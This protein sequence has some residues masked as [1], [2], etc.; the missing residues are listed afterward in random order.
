M[1]T[2]VALLQRL[3]SIAPKCWPSSRRDPIGHL[4]RRPALSAYHPEASQAGHHQP[5]TRPIP[6]SIS[7]LFL[8]TTNLTSFRTIS[9]RRPQALCICLSCS[10]P[11]SIISSHCLLHR[12]YNTTIKIL[13]AVHPRLFHFFSVLCRLLHHILVLCCV[14]SCSLSEP[15]PQFSLSLVLPIVLTPSSKPTKQTR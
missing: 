1:A 10:W 8:P 6:S 9:L 3:P 5:K 13:Y 12:P 7:I 4:L 14:T 2:A 11:V 15:P